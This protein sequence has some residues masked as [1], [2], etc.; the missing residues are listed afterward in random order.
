MNVFFRSAVVWL[1]LLVV[2]FMNGA[3]REFVL[4]GGL[5]LDTR[6]A[7]QLSC[8]TGTLLMTGFVFL[9]WAKLRVFKNHLGARVD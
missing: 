7:N 9:V 3:I 6:S 2:A 1:C 4:K 8:L 5:S